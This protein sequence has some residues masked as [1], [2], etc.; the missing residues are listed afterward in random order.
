MRRGYQVPSMPSL[1]CLSYYTLCPN[2]VRTL[3]LPDAAISTL[4]HQLSTLWQTQA[5][6]AVDSHRNV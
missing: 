1:H 6:R 2:N 5:V 4:L 3:Q